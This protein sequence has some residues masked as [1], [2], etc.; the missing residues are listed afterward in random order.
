MT[1]NYLGF[2]WCFLSVKGN[3]PNELII[4]IVYKYRGFMSPITSKI[5]NFKYDGYRQQIRLGDLFP[6]QKKYMLL[7]LLNRPE[8][9]ILKK[10]RCM[11][12]HIKYTKN[13]FIDSSVMYSTAT[14]VFKSHTQTL[15]H[16]EKKYGKELDKYLCKDCLDVC[17]YHY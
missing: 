11:M 7:N 17:D 12:C 15:L 1:L 9:I 5:E 2:I 6:Y 4:E 14:E 13:N 8:K 3:L 10:L 16:F